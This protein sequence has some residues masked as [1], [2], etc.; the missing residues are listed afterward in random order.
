MQPSVRR[1]APWAGHASGIVADACCV[2]PADQLS[3][4][5]EDGVGRASLATLG[6]GWRIAATATTLVRRQTV[7]RG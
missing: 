6:S 4:P 1:R 3:H 5:V 2:E 7:R